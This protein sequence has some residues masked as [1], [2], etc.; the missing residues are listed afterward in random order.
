MIGGDTVPHEL[1]DPH[2]LVNGDGR[3]VT[4]YL[5]AVKY[6][7]DK[8][9]PQLGWPHQIIGVVIV[10]GCMGKARSEPSH[11]ETRQ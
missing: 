6:R 1:V 4:L 3:L 5:V 10:V 2:G 8:F 7:H 9:D 11:G